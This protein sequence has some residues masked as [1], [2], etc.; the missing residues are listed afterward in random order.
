[1]GW[2]TPND[3]NTIYDSYLVDKA[4]KKHNISVY[5]EPTFKIQQNN[6]NNYNKNL[7]NFQ[8]NDYVYL[9]FKEELF[10]KSFD[11]QV[12]TIKIHKNYSKFTKIKKKVAF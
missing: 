10:G 2:L 12:N 4:R 3:I 1:M 8:V 6:V 11:T 5:R 7:K 9:D